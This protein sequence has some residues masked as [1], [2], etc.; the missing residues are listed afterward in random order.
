MSK[1]DGDGI[2]RVI[3]CTG[4]NFE[5]DDIIL[6]ESSSHTKPSL[7]GIGSICVQGNPWLLYPEE[8]FKGNAILIENGSYGDVCADL[9]EW[10]TNPGSVRFINEDFNAPEIQLMSSTQYKA[11]NPVWQRADGD[12][13]VN[14]TLMKSI[15]V[16]NG[17]IWAVNAKDNS[18]MCRLIDP[19][20]NKKLSPDSPDA[21]GSGW[22]KI[23]ARKFSAVREDGIIQVTKEGGC[24]QLCVG[25]TSVWA[26]NCDGRVVARVGI[27]EDSPTGREWATIDSEPLIH[28]SV[29]NNGHVWGIDEKEKI[30]YR[31]GATSKTT[32]GTTWKSISGKLKQVSVG[33]CGVWGINSEQSVYLR[34]NTYG[35]PESEGTGW[36]KIEGKFRSIYSGE[37]CV[38][39]LA[40]NRDVYYRA[41]AF[42]RGDGSFVATANNEGTHWVKIDQRKDKVIFKHVEA[43]ADTMWAVDKH[44]CVWFKSKASPDL[45][46]NPHHTFSTYGDQPNFQDRY[47]FPTKASTYKVASGG[48]ALYSEPDFKGKVMYHYGN[49]T[50]SN[51]PP[52]K[53]D[54]LKSYFTPIGSLR[55]MRGQHYKTPMIRIHPLWDEMTTK[56][57]EIELYSIEVKNEEE[58]P[59]SKVPWQR[60]FVGD[61]GAEHRFELKQAQNIAGVPSDV[62][63]G[64]KFKI[65]KIEPLV[66]QVEE[67]P[68]ETTGEL[69]HRQLESE[70]IFCDET[71]SL[72]GSTE[73][74]IVKLPPRIPPRCSFTVRVIQSKVTFQAPFKAEFKMGFDANYHLGSDT[75]NDSGFYT[76]V[77]SSNITVETGTIKMASNRKVSKMLN[78]LGDDM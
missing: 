74:K 62:I 15:S 49:E 22:M 5:G 33:Y 37:D 67:G 10:C 31:K 32:L 23:Q 25:T 56:V 26:V 27:S 29:S 12:R 70:F 64:C 28:V 43:A 73:K 1:S 48:W 16:G 13:N 44:C 2:S 66:F 50:L 21:P 20:V 58:V 39:A 3:F 54:E 7:K 47:K 65:N 38:I 72:R 41:N 40:S 24:K 36:I 45:N 53:E 69:F 8:G 51:D 76:G 35:D 30:W 75:W 71:L 9:G 11:D 42:D 19:S 59:D 34:M 68:E 18:V 4:T 52:S 55:P 6:N 14:S 60:T 63:R 61:I 46:T 78:G 57:E 17:G 77:D